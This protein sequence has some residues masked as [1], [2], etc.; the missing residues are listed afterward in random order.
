MWRPSAHTWVRY[1]EPPARPSGC[2][3]QASPCLLKL[4]VRQM[5]ASN[6]SLVDVFR[7]PGGLGVGRKRKPSCKLLEKEPVRRMVSSVR[8]KT[9]TTHLHHSIASITG[10]ALS[11]TLTREIST[12]LG[13][14][15]LEML[16]IRLRPGPSP[17]PQ[18]FQ[19]PEYVNT[20]VSSLDPTH[21]ISA[22]MQ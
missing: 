21:A 12:L 13:S 11:Q 9:T 5:A 8:Q 15:H 3:F 18:T 10:R 17:T 19:N 4:P 14:A 6:R 2:Q 22:S 7:I 20:S 16:F 1:L